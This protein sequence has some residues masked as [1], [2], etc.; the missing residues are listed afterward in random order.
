MTIADKPQRIAIVGYG[1]IGQHVY[2]SL[3]AALPASV[4]FAILVRTERAHLTATLGNANLF[5]RVD[6][7][8][9]WNPTLVLECAGHG[10]VASI[11]PSVLRSGTDVI[12]ASIG[13][14]ADEDLR[15]SLSTA[16]RDGSARVILISGGVGALDALKAASG[17]GLESVTYA[18][19]KAPMAWIGSPAES[20]FDL[21]SIAAATM[22]FSGNAAEAARLYPKNANVAAAIALVGVGFEKTRV[23]LIAD[24]SVTKNISEVTAAG[25]FGSLSLRIENNPMPE[26]P[27]TSM[28]AALSIVA[29][30]RMRFEPITL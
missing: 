4:A 21:A 29:K 23:E 30:V 11:V 28:L 15:Q 20:Q 5:C 14:L 3:R 24:P 17:A 1:A 8:L 9:A 27:R 2:R 10:A 12:L 26:N 25:A 13:A 6:E 19:R 7:L 16:A 22:V 18:G